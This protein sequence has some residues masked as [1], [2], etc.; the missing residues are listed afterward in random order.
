MLMFE[1]IV[2]FGETLYSITRKFNIETG[3]LLAVNPGIINP[4]VVIPGQIIYIPDRGQMK[5]IISANGFVFSATDYQTVI[6]RLPYLTYLSILGHTFQEDGTII[7]IDDMPLIQ[8]SR[9]AGVAPMLV[10]SNTDANGFYSPDLAHA[11]LADRQLKNSLIT[12]IGNIM[13]NKNYYGLVLDFEYLYP[14]DLFIYYEFLSLVNRS[15][16]QLGYVIRLVIRMNALM[17]QQEFLKI[18]FGQTELL[19]DI[20]R[21]MIMTNELSYTFGQTMFM[22]PLDQVQRALDSAIQSIPRTQIVLGIPNAGYDWAL[23]RNFGIPAKPLSKQQ[24]IERYKETGALLQYDAATHG[25]Y[26]SYIDDLGVGHI[27]WSEN[28][29]GFEDYL[30]LV[31]TYNLA[32]ISLLTIDL[33]TSADYQTLI[34]THDILKVLSPEAEPGS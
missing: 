16:R 34:A 30:Q 9:E 33:F 27:V 28:G 4:D 7:D 32:G 10:I 17:E 26:F 19:E 12:N 1:Y 3:E 14:S 25:F 5:R 18:A 11:I 22:S 15:M 20:N 13:V 24:T 2:N 31:N 21:F 23:P 29:H 8:M 6:E